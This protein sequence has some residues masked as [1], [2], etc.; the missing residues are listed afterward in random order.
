MEMLKDIQNIVQES[1]LV[2]ILNSSAPY[3]KLPAKI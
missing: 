3:G 2:N 1:Q